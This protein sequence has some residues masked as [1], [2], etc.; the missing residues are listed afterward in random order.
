[1]ACNVDEELERMRHAEMADC[2]DGDLHEIAEDIENEEVDFSGVLDE[3][4]PDADPP[5]PELSKADADRFWSLFLT[6]EKRIVAMIK[7][8]ESPLKEISDLARACGF[9]VEF[10]VSVGKKNAISLPEYADTIEIILS[11]NWNRNL[12]EQVEL[13]FQNVPKLPSGW[14]VSK[15]C[16]TTKKMLS[17]MKVRIGEEIVGGSEDIKYALVESRT[18]GKMDVILFA[19]EEVRN[20]LFKGGMPKDDAEIQSESSPLL[21]QLLHNIMGEYHILQT[22]GEIIVCTESPGDAVVLRN[23]V[24]AKKEMDAHAAM[25]LEMTEC[26]RCAAKFYN[27]CLKRC[28]RCRKTSYCGVKCQKAD[29]KT[30]KSVCV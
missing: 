26:D 3:L 10:R 8:G 12:C 24:D 13:L 23:V 16:I 5:V 25:G 4:K 6:G 9:L 11:A 29:Y 22:L 21:M 28:S 15:Y 14:T 27:V 30:H 20:G 18:P 1:M 7:K 19:P 2:F 17:D